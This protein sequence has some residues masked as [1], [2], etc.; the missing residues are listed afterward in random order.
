MAGDWERTVAEVTG[1]AAFDEH[2]KVVDP[3][4]HGLFGHHRKVTWSVQLKVYPLHSKPAEARHKV[5]PIGTIPVVGQ[6]TYVKRQDGGIWYMDYDRI[7][8]ANVEAAR[9]NPDAA[10]ALA[11]AGSL[12]GELL[13]LLPGVP[14]QSVPQWTPEPAADASAGTPPSAATAMLCPNCGA[15]LE[16]TVQGRCRSCGTPIDLHHT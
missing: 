2:G 12:A 13:V 3:A 5:D 7:H 4:D 14:R 15:P 1:V 16:L 6:Q 11:A 10:A 9:S 8:E